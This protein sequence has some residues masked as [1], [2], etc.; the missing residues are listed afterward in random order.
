MFKRGFSLNCSECLRS[1]YTSRLYLLEM[2]GSEPIL[3]INVHLMVTNTGTG[4]VCV[5]GPLDN[6]DVLFRQRL[7]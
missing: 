3:S 4:T 6:S 2:V 5:N 7:L 1:V